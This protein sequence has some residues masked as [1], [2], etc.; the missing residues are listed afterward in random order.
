MFRFSA[1]EQAWKNA[2]KPY[3]KEHVTPYI[4]EHSSLMGGDIFISAN[5]PSPGKYEK[6]R[7]TVDEEKDF[8]VISILIHDLG[9]EKGWLE[10]A[11]YYENNE[12]IH[13]LNSSI[14]RNE[15]YRKV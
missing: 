8:E 7:L 1:L 10:Y 13:E 14:K 3:Q 6:V 11:D 5:F 4:R 2:N 15:G 9:A 12:E